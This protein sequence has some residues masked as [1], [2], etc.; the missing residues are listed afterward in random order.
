M[1]NVQAFRAR[2]TG[3]KEKWLGLDRSV[4]SQ[5]DLARRE[6]LVS[7]ADGERRLLARVAVLGEADGRG[8]TRIGDRSSPRR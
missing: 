3:R 4:R 6:R 2:G 8:E 7:V 5:R 1:P